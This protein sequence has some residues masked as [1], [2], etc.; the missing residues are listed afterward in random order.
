MAL[1]IGNCSAQQAVGVSR[2]FVEGQVRN[3]LHEQIQDD[4]V[5]LLAGGAL[6]DPG[7]DFRISDDRTPRSPRF[8][9][10]KRAA[11]ETGRRCMI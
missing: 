10:S 2:G 5:V 7:A 11:T 1:A 3:P 8:S 6:L 9:D 4:V